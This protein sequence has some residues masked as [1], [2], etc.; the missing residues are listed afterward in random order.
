MF[1]SLQSSAHLRFAPRIQEA[2]ALL[3]FTNIVFHSLPFPSLFLTFF[4]NS[5][6]LIFSNPLTVP[7]AKVLSILILSIS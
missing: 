2:C 1:T 7:L 5:L 3:A 6:L 4:L